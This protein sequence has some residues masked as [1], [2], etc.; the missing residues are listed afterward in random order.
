VLSVESTEIPAIKIIT[1]KR[2]ADRRGFFMETYS[3]RV[4]MDA[5]IDLDFVQDSEAFSAFIERGPL[6]RWPKSAFSPYITGDS[7]LFINLFDFAQP[8]LSYRGGE[9]KDC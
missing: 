9:G 3:R 6:A 1:P 8:D 5:G 4:V 7:A 2:F